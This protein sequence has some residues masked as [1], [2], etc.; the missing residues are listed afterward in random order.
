MRNDARGTQWVNSHVCTLVVDAKIPFVLNPEHDIEQV[1]AERRDRIF[2][3][4]F[5]R[6]VSR[7]VFTKTTSKK[8]A[9]L[10]EDRSVES[11]TCETIIVER[12]RVQSRFLRINETETES[13]LGFENQRDRY[14]AQSP[15]L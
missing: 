13:S 5:T 2:H 3:D 10:N 7:D 15:F 4:M 9:D 1:G 6:C 14:R 12:D 11:G 8:D